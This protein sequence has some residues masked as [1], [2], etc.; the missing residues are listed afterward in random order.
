MIVK[1]YIDTSDERLYGALVPLAQIMIMAEDSD[2]NPLIMDF[3]D[4][5][6]MSPVFVLSLIVLF[7]NKQNISFKNLDSK[8]IEIGVET[9]GIKPDQMRW[10]EFIAIMER[11]LL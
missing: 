7:S 3:A 10:T 8:L 9:F 5:A 11:Y 6:Y 1:E 4:T 2:D